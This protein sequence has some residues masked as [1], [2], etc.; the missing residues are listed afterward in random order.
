MNYIQESIKSR[1]MIKEKSRRDGTLLTVDFNLRQ[2]DAMP[3][4]VPQGRYFRAIIVSSLRDFGVTLLCAFRRLK[5]TV[6]KMLSLRDWSQIVTS[7]PNILKHCSVMPFTLTEL[8]SIKEE[9]MKRKP[10]GFK[11]NE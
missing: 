4:E 10:I 11:Q 8:M 1:K 2:I 7:F 5:P 6:N 9:Q 3:S